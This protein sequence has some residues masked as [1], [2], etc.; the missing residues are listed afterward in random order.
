M[1]KRTLRL[2]IFAGPNGSGKSTIINAVRKYKVKGIP[3]DFGIYVNADDI[4]K[5]LRKGKLTFR[6]YRVKVEENEFLKIVKE[7]GLIDNNFSLT[8]FRN[9]ISLENLLL[10]VK[11]K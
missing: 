4:A 9:S 7:S 8:D 11:N 2:R 10:K 3:V 6:Q 5:R 1:I